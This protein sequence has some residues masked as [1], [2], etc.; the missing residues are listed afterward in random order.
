[1]NFDIE[2]RFL[3]DLEKSDYEFNR[4]DKAELG[5]ASLCVYGYDMD[6]PLNS[7]W[8]QV[9]GKLWGVKNH[10][11]S[12]EELELWGFVYSPYSIE[13]NRLNQRL[14]VS[15]LLT[16]S[17]NFPKTDFVI[18]N[19]ESGLG[20]MCFSGLCSA[21]LFGAGDLFDLISKYE[22]GFLIGV[23]NNQEF[24]KEKTFEF[25]SGLISI[26]HKT[27]NCEF[28][29]MKALE[30]VARLGCFILPVAWIETGQYQLDVFTKK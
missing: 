28:P 8:K 11:L 5:G 6:L 26:N 21:S 20:R 16:R 18:E 1:M 30:Y 4:Y 3:P 10:G 24:S 7:S 25:L 12:L 9:V 22:N 23:K 17:F 13:E 27:N 29:L 15:R 2:K 14:G 19:S